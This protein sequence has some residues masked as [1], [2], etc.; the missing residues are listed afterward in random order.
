MTPALPPAPP[1]ADAAPRAES[2]AWAWTSGVVA[3]LILYGSWFPF[4]WIHPHPDEALWALTNLDLWTSRE[5]LLGNVVLFLP[6]GLAAAMAATA[7]RGRPWAWVLL[8]GAGLALLAQAGQFFEAHRDPRWADVV[9]N[10]V[11]AGLGWAASG[12][13]PR[14]AGQAGTA[15]WALLAGS[16][17]A[18]WLPWWPSL[19]PARLQWHWARLTELGAW[20]GPEAAMMA[21]LTLVAGCGA[22]WLLGGPTTS[23]GPGRTPVSAIV[24]AGLVVVLGQALVPG[25]RFSA[26]GVL[27]GLLGIG[28]ALGL[29][30]HPRATAVALGT[31]QVL[32]GLAP[33]DLQP[34]PVQ[35]LHWLPFE[36]L[37][38]G[39]MLG[40]AQALARDAW[41]WGCA[42]WFARQGGWPLA[43]ATAVC[44]ALALA[45]EAVQ[46]W[47]P[48]RTADVTPALIVLGLGWGLAAWRAAHRSSRG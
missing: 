18:A 17:G 33:F 28:L 3:A 24:A 20:Q 47:M 42:L 38:G 7:R 31:L 13:V 35:A 29:W 14:R 27:G 1:P 40:N 30:R 23:H 34:Q 11:G 9:W 36:A 45:V 5:D 19:D 21:G 26:G 46:C 10:L 25:S 37:L 44:A 15:A 4:H 8:G 39:S 48:S 12:I 43:P 6:W 41:L 32:G 2:G 16:A 22:A